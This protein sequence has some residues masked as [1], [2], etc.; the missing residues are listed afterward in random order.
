[1]EIYKMSKLDWIEVELG[2]YTLKDPEKYRP[3]VKL[4]LKNKR[5]ENGDI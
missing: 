3:L 2:V 5:K 1:M 4:N